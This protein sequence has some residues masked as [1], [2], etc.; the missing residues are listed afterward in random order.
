LFLSQPLIRLS[1]LR[2]EN[3]SKFLLFSSKARNQVGAQRREDSGEGEGIN[4]PEAAM[5]WAVV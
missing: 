3:I 5:N 2:R 1:S 4:N